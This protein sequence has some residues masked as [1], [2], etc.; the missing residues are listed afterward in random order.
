MFS[1]SGTFLPGF[2]LLRI[3]YSM[4][5]GVKGLVVI[6][7]IFHFLASINLSLSI[8]KYCRDLNLSKSIFLLTT[9]S[10]QLDGVD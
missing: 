8:K 9:I 2:Y 4:G 6:I 5:L 10:P 3:S 7:S 1:N